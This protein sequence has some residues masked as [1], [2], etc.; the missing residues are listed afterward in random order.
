[1]ARLTMASW[2]REW[3]PIVDKEVFSVAKVTG[4]DPFVDE[5][6]VI[7][8]AIIKG[9]RKKRR[10]LP[11]RMTYYL[12]KELCAKIKDI[13]QELEVPISDVAHYALRDFATRY[14]KGEIQ[15]KP[16][17]WVTRKKLI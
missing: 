3:H 13:A 11:Y 1:M 7:T 9:P 6:A 15:L 17:V 8:H 5:K 12:P 4:T 16:R 10:N 14:S 2:S